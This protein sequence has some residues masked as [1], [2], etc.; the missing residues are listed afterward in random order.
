M[1]RGAKELGVSQAGFIEYCV[2]DRA[3]QVVQ[4]E[5]MLHHFATMTSLTPDLKLAIRQARTAL[6]NEWMQDMPA[7]LIPSMRAV[8]RR[9]RRRSATAK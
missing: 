4:H 2:A 3:S 5:K 8:L 9:H 7:G 1:L 6:L